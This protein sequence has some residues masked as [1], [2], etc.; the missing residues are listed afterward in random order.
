MTFYVLARSG[1]RRPRTIRRANAEDVATTIPPPWRAVYRATNE[2]DAIDHMMTVF[3]QHD[4]VSI[5]GSG[6]LTP[7]QAHSYDREASEAAKGKA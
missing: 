4:E 6:A 2:L 7:E 3:D 5:V 1:R